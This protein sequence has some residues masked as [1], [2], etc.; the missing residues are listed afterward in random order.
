MPYFEILRHAVPDIH[1][2]PVRIVSIVKCPTGGVEL[3]RVLHH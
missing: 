3:V 1:R 2:L